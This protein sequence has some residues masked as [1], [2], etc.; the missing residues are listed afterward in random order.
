[1]LVSHGIY[2]GIWRFESN[3]KDQLQAWLEACLFVLRMMNDEQIDGGLATV[4][5]TWCKRNINYIGVCKDK[6]VVR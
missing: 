2:A 4:K 1:M 6:Y 3:Y 5:N